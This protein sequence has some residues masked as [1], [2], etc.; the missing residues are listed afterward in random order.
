MNA[1]L[2][3][4]LKLKKPDY[5]NLLWLGCA[6]NEFGLVKM[7]SNKAIA[8]EILKRLCIKKKGAK[9][10][11]EKIEPGL[12]AKIVGDYCSLYVKSIPVEELNG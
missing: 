5:E 4:S 9:I 12:I 8:L 11:I 7:V 3:N 2:D 6:E 1:Y 10:K